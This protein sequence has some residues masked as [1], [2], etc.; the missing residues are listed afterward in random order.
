[1]SKAPLLFPNFFAFREPDSFK[2]KREKPTGLTWDEFDAALRKVTFGEPFK[3]FEARLVPSEEAGGMAIYV[4]MK[5]P[6]R[7]TGKLEY[8]HSRRFCTAK[9]FKTERDVFLAVREQMILAL[10]HEVDE[11]LL[12]DGERIFD[13]HLEGT[14]LK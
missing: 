10:T 3:T 11:S 9:E 13:P 2:L 4:I 6:D 7:V 1:M 12:V 8:L 5:T 14:K